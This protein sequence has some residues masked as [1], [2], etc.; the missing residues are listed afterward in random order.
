MK[1]FTK[2]NTSILVGGFFIFCAFSAQASS[3]QTQTF[4]SAIDYGDQVNST[5]A[6]LD[7]PKGMELDANKDIYLVDTTNNKI[8]K[9]TKHDQNLIRVA[10]TGQYGYNNGDAL[11]AQFAG[12]EDI[13]VY[14]N[15][16]QIFVADTGNNVVRKIENGQVSTLISSL[17]QPKGLYLY[18]DTLFIADSGNN[19]ILAVDRNGGTPWVVAA[20]LNNP[21]KLLFWPQARSIIFVNYDAETVEAVNIDTGDRPASLAKELE[22]IGGVYRQGRTLY[23]F[24]SYSIGV[25]NEIW[26]VRLKKPK[27]TSTPNVQSTKRISYYR[28]TEALNWPSDGFISEDKLRWEEYYT[29]DTNLLYEE[30]E[31][32]ASGSGYKKPK[33]LDKGK[34]KI[35]KTRK[36]GQRKWRKKWFVRVKPKKEWQTAKFVLKQEHQGDWPFFRVQLQQDNKDWSDQHRK[37]VRLKNL[38]PF[39]KSPIFRIAPGLS[40]PQNLTTKNRGAKKVTL[41]W[42]KVTNGANYKIQLWKVKKGKDKRILTKNNHQKTKIKINKKHLNANQQYKFR[43]KTI[44]GERRS[45]WS[46]YKNFRTKP[47]AVKEVL[48]PQPA[49]GKRIKKLKSG[50]YLVTL[51][52]RL[53]SD[54]KD[55]KRKNLRAKVQLLSQYTEHAKNVNKDRLY[56]LYKGGSSIL[57]WRKNGSL[58]T[59]HA[60]KHR[61]QD[62]YGSQE[63]AL[64]GRPKAIAFSSDKTKM[65]ISENNKIVLYDLQTKELSEV[66]GHLMDSY[67]EGKGDNVRFSDVT[68]MVLS[69]DDKWLYLVDRNNHRIRK[70]NTNTGKTKYITGA[71]GTNFSFETLD[72]NGYQE[73]GPCDNEFELGVAGCAYFNRPTGIA[74]SPDGQTL[75]V[76]E[77]SNNRVRGVNISTGQTWLIAGSGAAGFRNGTGGAA[78]FN[79]PYTLDVSDDGTKLYVADKYNHA[80]REIVLSNN[81]VTT[82][83]GNG[84]IGNREGSFSSAVL[85]IPEYLRY[86]NNTIYWTEA[87]TNTIRAANLN[88]EKVFTVSG[89]GDKGFRDGNGSNAQWNNPKGFDFRGNKMYV[90]DYYNDLIRTIEF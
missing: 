19:R 38:S 76:A 2:F 37:K 71:G 36:V 54:R 81:Q 82:L 29:W 24:S 60:G 80:V 8:E 48:Q 85:A 89:N 5:E 75:Y 1:K 79:G 43:V 39:V 22:D 14:G 63:E 13:A 3:F 47:G 44:K 53:P 50:D 86:N 87:G 74:I 65:Y 49:R 64:I 62:E 34:K 61:F 9:I 90:A 6:Y 23:I 59:H 52:Y 35:L 68:D 51:K 67:V 15:G 32:Q 4:L 31:G 17:K 11:N 10:G 21:T 33:N 66:A 84:K 58:P 73:G 26:K 45:V 30:S 12:P 27:S 41:D 7:E 78:Q 88:S 16:E 25:F 40:A 20:G 42:E 18:Q 55:Y 46:D 83:F 72:S 77:G 57:I 69:P 28:E 56:V 70:L